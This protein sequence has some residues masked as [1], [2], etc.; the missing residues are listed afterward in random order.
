M[1]DTSPC[2][3][4]NCRIW[5]SHYGRELNLAEKCRLQGM[6]P[7]RLNVVVSKTQFAKQLGNSMS[8]NVLERI[9]AAA[10]PAAGLSAPLRD[11]WAS[12]YAVADLEA[13]RNVGLVPRRNLKLA[14]CS[15]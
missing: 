13:T 12:G 5:I 1:R 15:L 6:S 3:M 11:R 4:T 2:L 14:Q 8:V 7:R 9:L 10:L